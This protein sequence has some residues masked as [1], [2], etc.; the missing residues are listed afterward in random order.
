[1]I[2]VNTMIKVVF[3]SSSDSLSSSISD[4]DEKRELVSKPFSYECMYCTYDT[5]CLV[6]T[7]MHVHTQAYTL[8]T[9]RLCWHNNEHNRCLKALSIMLA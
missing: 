3:P 2:I 9:R 1:M 8:E 6:H 4:Y 5:R 7:H